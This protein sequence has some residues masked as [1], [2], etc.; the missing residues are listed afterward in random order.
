[1][2]NTGRLRLGDKTPMLNGRNTS[3]H[4]AIHFTREQAI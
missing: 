2:C 4:A 3:V 1:M